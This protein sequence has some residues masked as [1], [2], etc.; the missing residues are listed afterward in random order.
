MYLLLWCK[1][2]LHHYFSFQCHMILQKSSWYVNAQET[3]IIII[4]NVENR[5]FS[6]LI[7]EQH[8]LE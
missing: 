1:A 4:N 7:S 5:F 6:L 3:F 2:Y 8:L